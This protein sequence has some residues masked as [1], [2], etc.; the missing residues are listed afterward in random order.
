M[1]TRASPSQPLY[2][3]E[4]KAAWCE[5]ILSG[6][7]SLEIRAYP[8]PPELA[9]QRVL[10][11]ASSGEEGVA[12]FGDAIEAG[13]A[14]GSVVG[15]VLFDGA[16]AVEY[17]SGEA[18]AADAAVHCVPADSPYAYREGG[19][20]LYGWPVVASHRFAELQPLPAMRRL[21]RSVYKRQG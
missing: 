15:W 19:P 12:A 4:C 5:R 3:L 1:E 14:G 8:P 16:A 10:L 20:A 18:F 2:G 7:K 11:L 13:Q 9:G 21:M 17:A 6:E